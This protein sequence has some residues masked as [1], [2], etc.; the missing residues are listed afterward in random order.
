MFSLVRAVISLIE[1]GAA[2][3]LASPAPPHQDGRGQTAWSFTG[4]R[5]EL[6]CEIAE[7]LLGGGTSAIDQC[8]PGISSNAQSRPFAGRNSPNVARL[9]ALTAL[10]G[11]AARI[12]NR[13]AVASSEVPLCNG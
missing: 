1:A 6:S 11:S 5:L 10:A 13:A 8:H 12:F 2:P 9:F 7:S 4:T 3:V